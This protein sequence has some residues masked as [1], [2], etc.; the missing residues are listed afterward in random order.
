ME[1]EVGA[2]GAVDEVR[3]GARARAKAEAGADKP[4]LIIVDYGMGNLRSAQK[5]LERAGC[6]AQITDSAE[7]ITQAR[8]VILPGVGAFPDAMKSLARLGLVEA[9][10]E[11]AASGV[12]IL[13]ICLGMQLLFSGSEE[14]GWHPGLGLIPGEVRK[15][16][17]GVKIPHMGWN[18]VAPTPAAGRLFSATNPGARFYFIHSYYVV[19]DE[20]AA[21]AGW[22]EYGVRFASVVRR[23]RVFGFQFHPEKSS[24]EGLK[25]LKQFGELVFHAGDSRS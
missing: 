7:A 23:G 25:L 22:T 20:E 8:G 4:D 21:V 12:P 11:A 3:A 18:T 10:R 14:G 15:L 19:P 24:T 6:R 16:P 1:T 9:I 13:G 5:G 17:E 2:V